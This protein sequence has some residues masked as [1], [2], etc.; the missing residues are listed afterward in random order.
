MIQLGAARGPADAKKDFQSDLLPGEKIFI[1][2]GQLFFSL[3]LRTSKQFSHFTM[4][5]A[6]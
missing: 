3:D 1:P 5:P 4:G 2:L 6:E